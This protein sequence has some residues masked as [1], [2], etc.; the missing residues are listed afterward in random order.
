[1]DSFVK[2]GA[3]VVFRVFFHLGSEQLIRTATVVFGREQKKAEAD[4]QHLERS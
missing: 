3:G 1:M 2:Q 4:E